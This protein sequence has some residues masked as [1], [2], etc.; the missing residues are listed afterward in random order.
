[1]ERHCSALK[2]VIAATAQLAPRVPVRAA[3]AAQHLPALTGLRFFLALWVMLHHLT[4]RGQMLEAAALA[5]P[6]PVYELIRGG[7]LAVTTFFVLSGFV[8]SRSYAETRWNGRGLVRYGM[9]RVARVYPVY[10]LSLA[11]VAPFIAADRTPGRGPLLAAHGLLVQGWMGSLP[12]N[13]N[14]PAWSLSCEMFFYIV[15]PLAAV[16]I[17]RMGWKG[18]AVVAA[19]TC[20]MT[21]VMLA[22][23]VPDPVKPLIHLSD[24]LMGVAAAR[25]F[26]CTQGIRNGQVAL[27]YM[28]P[29]ALGASA[30]LIARPSLLPAG[31][32][33][34]SALRPLNAAMLIGLA[35]GGGMLAR[36]LSARVIVYLG[37]ASYAMYILHVPILWWFLRWHGTSPAVYIALVIGVSAVVYG[38]FEEP[39][40]RWLRGRIP[41]LL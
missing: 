25:I 21:R 37:K 28:G 9:G 31:V 7:Y 41:R 35:A 11:V 19:G 23:G 34:N 29:A 10:L 30:V 20:V 26:E 16:G 38:F 18:A 6:G 13:W 22:C 1:M 27:R 39:A 40:N 3:A 36:G 24:F 12:V 32:D 14:T 8:L 5:L 33:L 17:L 15:F 2:W 4:G